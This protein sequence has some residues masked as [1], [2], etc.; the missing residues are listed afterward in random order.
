MITCL[1]NLYIS[2]YASISNLSPNF[3]SSE[4]QS[5]VNDITNSNKLV[6][7]QERHFNI[8]LES[9]D[10]Y[11]TDKDKS[12]KK[13]FDAFVEAKNCKLC[14]SCSGCAQAFYAQI[15]NKLF[16]YA[17]LHGSYNY[18]SEILDA[19]KSNKINKFNFNNVEHYLLKYLEDRT[20]ALEFYYSKYSQMR[21][22][23]SLNYKLINLKGLSSST[24]T[25]YNNTFDSNLSGGGFYINWNNVGIA[26][27]PGYN[28]VTNMHKKGIFILDI[29]IVIITHEHID[30]TCDIRTI[31]DLNYQ[32]NSLLPENDKHTIHWYWDEKTDEIYRRP[33]TNQFNEFTLIRNLKETPF[34]NDVIGLKPD[35]LLRP[36]RTKHII[37]TYQPSLNYATHTYGFILELVS[38]NKKVQIG[39]TSDTTYF[40]NLFLALNGVDLLVANISSIH[41][42][43][44]LRETYK[45]THL[46]F[47]GCISLLEKLSQAPKYFIISEFWCGKDDIRYDIAKYISS[48]LHNASNSI[49]TKVLPAEVGLTINLEK[50]HIQ[51]SCCAQYSN[52]ITI[53]NPYKD[54][55][56]IRYL[57]PNC[58]YSYH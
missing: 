21:R 43:D 34:D 13:L 40:D 20:T 28:F 56:E 42:E 32:I 27:D 2:L 58:S 5:L 4:F 31:D 37:T 6:P 53:A 41:K 30:H 14:A 47:N 3:D 29:D 36:I 26:I 57:C 45:E 8:F 7:V 17:E 16:S 38:D 11:C 35:I 51:C 19:D 12:A 39:Y 55:E 50:M 46:G 44:L 22:M 52:T 9:L 18:W 54:Y 15:A 24:P 49:S 10:Y 33:L 23:K 25:I 1:Y 48:Q